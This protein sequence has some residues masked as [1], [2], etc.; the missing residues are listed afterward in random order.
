MRI[1]MREVLVVEEHAKVLPELQAAGPLGVG[2]MG[3]A[4]GVSGNR[5]I[6]KQGARMDIG[7]HPC[8]W[9]RL[10]GCRDV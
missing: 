9:Q 1:E 7:H 6:T 4:I 5:V 2:G 10:V 8:E 3:S